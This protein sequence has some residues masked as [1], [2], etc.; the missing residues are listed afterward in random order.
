MKKLSFLTA[1]IVSFSVLGATALAYTGDISINGQQIKF[2]SYDFL[3]GNT[4]RIYATTTN[5]GGQDLLGVVRFYDNG[6]QVGA[7]QP[8]SI[9]GNSTDDVFIDWTPL[10]YGTKVISVEMTPWVVENDDPSNNTIQSEKYVVQDTDHD[11][12]P[13]DSDDDDDGDGVN[14]TDDDFPL[15]KNEQHDTDGDGTGDNSDDDDDNDGVPDEHDGLPL[16]PN[17]TVDTDGDG[18]GDNTDTD[19]DGDGLSDGEEENKKTDPLNPDTD[20]DLVNDG[21]D[22]F[23]LDPEEWADTDGDGIGDNTD[24]DDDNDSVYDE[25]DEFPLNKG[26]IIKLDDENFTIDVLEEY[27]F[28][29]SPSY[30]EDGQ[31][32]SYLWDIDGEEREGN[33]VPYI[34]E[35]IG[36][37]KVGLTITDNNGESRSIE[38][39]A[40]VVNTKFYVQLATTLAAIFLALI[41]VFKYIHRAEKS[42]TK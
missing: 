40:N 16:D 32:V 24:T 19:D 15:N 39:Q 25:V 20:G 34:F 29:A 8:V 37:H 23:P 2:S 1:L 28:D 36:N 12:T 14:D 11:G 7:D 30:D 17:E 21:E 27:I 10:S 33:A 26:P 9:F 6:S 42:E 3:E 38:L 31:I 4:V 18:I 5:H 13:N 41:I 35:K 22:A